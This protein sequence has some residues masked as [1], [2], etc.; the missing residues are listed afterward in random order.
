MHGSRTARC[1]S[2]ASVS[3]PPSTSRA[4]GVSAHATVQALA[5]GGCTQ[6]VQLGTLYFSDA[7]ETNWVG[8]CTITCA[9]FV[10]GTGEPFPGQGGTCQGNTST[11]YQ[12][13]LIGA[14]HGCRE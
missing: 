10:R 1:A 3:D 13:P 2:C 5:P 12:A 7:A 4:I 8:Q 6:L 11:S 9:Q 14:C